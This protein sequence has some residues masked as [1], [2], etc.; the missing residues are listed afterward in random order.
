MWGMEII[1][2]SNRASQNL[3]W[4][5]RTSSIHAAWDGILNIL[6]VLNYYRCE[7]YL[8]IYLFFAFYNLIIR[9]Q[10]FIS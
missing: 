3:E 7:F 8:F 1:K 4:L 6:Q 5:S 2:Q 10:K 9:V